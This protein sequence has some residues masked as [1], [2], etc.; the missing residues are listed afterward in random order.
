MEGRVVGHQKA[1]QSLNRLK[2]LKVPVFFAGRMPRYPGEVSRKGL[3]R[4]PKKR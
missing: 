3:A 4:N 1:A 2:A